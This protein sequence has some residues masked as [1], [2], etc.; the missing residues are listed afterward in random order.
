MF[1]IREFRV[2]FAAT[3][4]SMP[5]NIVA[6]LALSVLLYRRTGSA[7]LA[8]S[9]LAL[10]FVPYLGGVAL[11]ALADRLPSRAGLVDATLICALFAGLMAIPGMPIPVLLLLI[12]GIGT[13]APFY[14]GIRTTVLTE[15]LPGPSYMLG[16]SLL[17]IVSQLSQVGG[18]ALGGLLLAVITPGQALLFDAATFLVAAGLLQV[19]TPRRPPRAASSGRSA[20]RDSLAVLPMLRANRRLRNSCC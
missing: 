15:V 6:G 3:S 14:G 11:S 17:Q 4:I 18:Y 2:R 8:A 10:E 7:F 20:F 5:G 1:S 13:V 16:T 9:A 19:G 12:V